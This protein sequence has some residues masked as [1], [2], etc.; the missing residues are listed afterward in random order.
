MSGTG[1]TTAADDPER[2]WAR[3]RWAVLGWFDPH[4]V[5]YRSPRPRVPRGHPD[6]RPLGQFQSTVTPRSFG[7]RGAGPW[8]FGPAPGVPHPFEHGAEEGRRVV[9]LLHAVDAAGNARFGLDEAGRRRFWGRLPKYRPAPWMDGLLSTL[10]P[11]RYVHA[12]VLKIEG[13][14]MFFDYDTEYAPPANGPWHDWGLTAFAHWTGESDGDCWFFDLRGGTVG[15]LYVGS[16]D[17]AGYEDQLGSSYWNFCDPANWR[18][19]L[20]D[21]CLKRGWLDE[22]AAGRLRA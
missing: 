7:P 5:L 17:D 16:G 1:D 15:S 14:D 10:V 20:V 3:K 6:A 13:P 19:F 2:E 22:A 9:E 12:G 11:D 18:R 4:S 8:T 21:E